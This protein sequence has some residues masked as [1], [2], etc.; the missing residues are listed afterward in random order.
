MSIRCEK[1]I[2][3]TESKEMIGLKSE[4]RDCVKTKS[5]SNLAF[6]VFLF[7]LLRISKC[8]IFFKVTKIAIFSKN[9][10]IIQHGAWGLC[11]RPRTRFS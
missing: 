8:V 1:E 3:Y 2:T 9:K 7:K 4:L 5:F 10:I 11:P 6:T